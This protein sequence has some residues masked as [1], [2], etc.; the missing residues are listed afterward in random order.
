MA[1]IPL[2]R[3]NTAPELYRK[4]DFDQLIEDISEIVNLL[5]STYQKDNNDE[6]ERKDWFLG[7]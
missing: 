2:T 3:L 6:L 4:I 5:N 7:G 1:K